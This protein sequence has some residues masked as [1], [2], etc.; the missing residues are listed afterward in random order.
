MVHGLLV[1]AFLGWVMTWPD[2]INTTYISLP[3]WLLALLL[4]GAVI[5][6]IAVS[7]LVASLALRAFRRRLPG[8]A[9]GLLASAIGLGVVLGGVAI[10]NALR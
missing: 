3:W 8:W 1:L 2:V 9:A 4:G 5:L 6:A 10:W 7:W